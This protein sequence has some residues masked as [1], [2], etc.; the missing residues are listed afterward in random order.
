MIRKII[1]VDMDA[2]YASIEQRDNPRYRNKPVIVGGPP[3]TRSVVA[4]CSYQARK[5]GIHSA[6]S[7]N[8]A[9]QLCPQAIFVSPRF[10]VYK[11]VSQQ[12]RKI[13]YKYT[14]LVEPLSLDEA[15]LDVTEN[16]QNIESATVI[17][18][19]IKSEIKLKT[20][21]TAS[22]G[23]SINKFVAKVASDYQKPDGLTV[24]PPDKVEIFLEN[25]DIEKFYGIGKVT[26]KKMRKMGINRGRD[27]KLLTLEQLSDHFGK[28]GKWY[29][30]IVRGLDNR[31]VN[32]CWE[33][34]SLGSETTLKDDISNRKEIIQILKNISEKIEYLMKK[35]NYSAKTVTLKVRY[36]NF[37]TV[38]R[39]ITLDYYVNGAEDII[40]QVSYLLKH[41]QAGFRK[42]RLLG[43]TMSNLKSMDQQKENQQSSLFN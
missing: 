17:A 27:L 14:D 20:K 5:F 37:E 38:T 12:I 2:F 24:I 31:P 6:M 36:K 35:N 26:E 16:H 28:V 25:L 9:H 21:L 22:A 40:K 39:S 33:R 15:F 10:K 19:L 8:K 13:F 11:A 43:I 41:T 4:T 3:H 30:H 42:V 34:K 1:H 32:P 18:Q 29:Y 7:S 23:V